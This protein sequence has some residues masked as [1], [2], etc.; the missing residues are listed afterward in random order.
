MA[1]V[2]YEMVRLGNAVKV[3]AIDAKTGIEAVVVGSAT[4]SHYSLEQAALRKLQRLL[5]NLRDRR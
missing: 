5:Q 1:E 2:L 4:M 3:T